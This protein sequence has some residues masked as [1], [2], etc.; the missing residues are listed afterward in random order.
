[1]SVSTIFMCEYNF[2]ECEY[3]FYE[4][5]YN[6]YEC[7]YNFYECEYNFPR[8]VRILFQ[9]TECYMC[10]DLFVQILLRNVA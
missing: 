5:E 4:C 9:I 3:N 6:F 10:N 7:E 2:Y 1:M 8:K